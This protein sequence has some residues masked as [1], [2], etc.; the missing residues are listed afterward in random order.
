MGISRWLYPPIRPGRRWPHV[1]ILT[2][3]SAVP[4]STSFVGRNG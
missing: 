3:P 1:V 2:T 4:R